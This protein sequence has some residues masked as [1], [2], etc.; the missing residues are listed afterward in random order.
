MSLTK[1]LI[2]GSPLTFQEMDDNLDYLEGLAQD[3]SL[4]KLLEEA[5]ELA[6]TDFPNTYELSTDADLQAGVFKSD[7]N[8]PDIFSTILFGNPNDVN[9]WNQGPVL[10]NP[11]GVFIGNKLSEEL[12]NGDSVQVITGLSL[13]VGQ[14]FPIAGNVDLLTFDELVAEG[15]LLC[16]LKS[17]TF[18]VNYQY[19]DLGSGEYIHNF[20]IQLLA[21]STALIQIE[22]DATTLSNV[23]LRFL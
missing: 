21:S 12:Q 18:T 13:P 7:Y 1:R 22:G 17:V 10:D 2:K 4:Q 3:Q 9:N 16:I 5:D 20:Y 11:E 19:E 15:T 23:D 6:R 8:F 14:D